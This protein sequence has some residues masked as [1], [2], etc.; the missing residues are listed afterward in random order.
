MRPLRIRVRAS[1][2][3]AVGQWWQERSGMSPFLPRRKDRMEVLA[4]NRRP[5]P[6]VPT[7]ERRERLGVQV[8]SAP[9]TK[10]ERDCAECPER[11]V[12]T[13]AG[14]ISPP[15]A[16]TR[17]EIDSLTD[18][19]EVPRSG[20]GPSLFDLPLRRERLMPD[21]YDDVR[22]TSPRPYA[23]PPSRRAVP[24]RVGPSRCLTTDGGDGAR[25]RLPSLPIDSPRESVVH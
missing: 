4:S 21:R 22:R 23:L 11:M 8:W 13:A 6:I 24:P 16:E 15:P 20:D 1:L 10:V 9:P 5:V 3:G 17:A 19:M 7:P 14:P 12:A 18:R 2:R 25:V